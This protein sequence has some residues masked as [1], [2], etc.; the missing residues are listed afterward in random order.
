MQR[1]ISPLQ[2]ERQL[3]IL[4]RDLFFL[5]KKYGELAQIKNPAIID[6]QDDEDETSEAHVEVMKDDM[7][8]VYVEPPIITL[9]K[10]H[11]KKRKLVQIYQL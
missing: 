9:K 10:I 6:T 1:D 7:Q 3:S 4:S 2:S 8:D 5:E 11:S